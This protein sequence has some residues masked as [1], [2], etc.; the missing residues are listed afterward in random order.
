[1]DN[2]FLIGSSERIVKWESYWVICKKSQ[3]GRFRPSYCTLYSPES[4]TCWLIAWQVCYTSKVTS[5]VIWLY[6]ATIKN[7]WLKGILRRFVW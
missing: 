6:W 1:M 7:L 5:P 2:I 4:Y 3:L